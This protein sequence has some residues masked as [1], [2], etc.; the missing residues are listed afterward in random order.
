MKEQQEGVCMCE[1]CGVG[2]GGGLVVPDQ[3]EHQL[4]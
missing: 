3:P 2:R 4:V 1:E